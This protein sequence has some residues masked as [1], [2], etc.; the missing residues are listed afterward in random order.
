M[1]QNRSRALN[2]RQSMTE[3]KDPV[4]RSAEGWRYTFLLF[5]CMLQFLVDWKE[6]LLTYENAIDVSMRLPVS[7]NPPSL[8]PE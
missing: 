5:E 4:E 2:R 7:F 3:I 1:N 6:L 8:P